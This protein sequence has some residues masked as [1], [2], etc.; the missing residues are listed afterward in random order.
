MWSADLEGGAVEL[1][2]RPS[3]ITRPSPSSLFDAI[4][5][6]CDGPKNLKQQQQ[7]G[8]CVWVTND[9]QTIPATY[10]AAWQRYL[11]ALYRACP[12][13]FA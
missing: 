11:A 13:T 1:K 7:V 2:V 5:R 3:D 4:C 6:Y 12:S 8:M 10:V 9:I